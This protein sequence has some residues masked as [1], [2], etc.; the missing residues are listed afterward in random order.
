MTE[1]WPVGHVGGVAATWLLLG[2][3]VKA[4][5]GPAAILTGKSDLFPLG[6]RNLWQPKAAQDL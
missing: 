2:H 6:K 1:P 3:I 4:P 5:T